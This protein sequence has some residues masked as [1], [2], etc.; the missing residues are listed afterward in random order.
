ML[1]RV[2]DYETTGT[3]EEAE[4]EICAMGR[5]DLL[6]ETGTITNGWDTL[7][8]TRGPMPPQARAVHHISDADLADAPILRDMLDPF[9]EGFGEAD[10][11]AAHNAEFEKHFTPVKNLRWICTY[12]AARVVWPDAPG[13]S[14]QCLRYWLGIDEDE[15]FAVEDAMPPHAALP[16]AYVTAFILRRLLKEKSVEELVEIS[17]WPA[18]L[19]K[20]TFGKHKGMAYA[21]APADYLEWI[22]DKS[23][24]DADTKFSARYWLQKRA[25]TTENGPSN[26]GLTKETT[27]G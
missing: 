20:L 3:P 12:K 27:N 23:D 8:C 18:L 16:D 24:M 13:H 14:N 19:K 22:R 26:N 10:V 9:F 7:I 5:I 25:K 15:D 2:I 4:A 1:I 11:A 17:K 21:E 6:P